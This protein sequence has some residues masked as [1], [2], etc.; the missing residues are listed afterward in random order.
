MSSI[1]RAA[2]IPMKQSVSNRI[3]MNKYR[4][5]KNTQII[6]YVKP[7]AH[8]WLQFQHV[9][10]Q[11]FVLKQPH[12]GM[13]HTITDDE[14]HIWMV[15]AFFEMRENKKSRLDDGNWLHTVWQCVTNVTMET[16]SPNAVTKVYTKYRKIR[17]YMQK[18]GPLMVRVGCRWLHLLHQPRAPPRT[19]PPDMLMS[20]PVM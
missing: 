1:L 14:R 17:S 15:D 20:V 10:P 8:V 11:A 13:V 19:F 9:K 7:E 3:N 18:K 2:W 6:W 12:A 16:N 5:E 4:S